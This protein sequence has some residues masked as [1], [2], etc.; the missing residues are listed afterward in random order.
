MSMTPE[1]VFHYEVESSHEG[2][3]P[4]TTIA[5]HGRLVGDTAKPIEKRS[6]NLSFPKEAESPWT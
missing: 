5:C 1:A 4:S 2:A 3:A 6:S